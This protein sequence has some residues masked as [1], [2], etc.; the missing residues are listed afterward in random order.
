MQI[1]LDADLS[2]TQLSLG[3]TKPQESSQTLAVIGQLCT[4]QSA[5]KRL[6]RLSF[7]GAGA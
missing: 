7:A 3:P 2:G 4:A 5:P 1:R 6:T